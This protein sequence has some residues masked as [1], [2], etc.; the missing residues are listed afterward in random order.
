MSSA[1]DGAPSITY[2]RIVPAYILMRFCDVELFRSALLRRSASQPRLRAR[3]GYKSTFAY[4]PA[5]RMVWLLFSFCEVL[6]LL[7][8]AVRQSPQGWKRQEPRSNG[9][10]VWVL[11]L[12]SILC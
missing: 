10:C 12:Q 7:L 2:D 9:C 3:H 4:I 11:V 5:A 6:T 1:H 8:N